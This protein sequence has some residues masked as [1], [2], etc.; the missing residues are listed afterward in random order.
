MADAAPE[1]DV[2]NE[3][4]RQ[5]DE[6]RFQH[7]NQ[8]L[9]NPDL[10]QN[11]VRGRV[12]VG[13]YEDEGRP[14]IR[15][16]LAHRDDDED[17]EDDA[18]DDL[19]F[20]EA[21]PSPMR[22]PRAPA[23]GGGGAGDDDDPFVSLYGSTPPWGNDDEEDKAKR[24]ELVRLGRSTDDCFLCNMRSTFQTDESGPM[25]LPEATLQE[26]ML[27]VIAMQNYRCTAKMMVDHVLLH[28]KN[29]TRPKILESRGLNERTRLLLSRPWFRQTVYDH[30]H[31]HNTSSSV[32][33]F[34][35]KRA[36]IE[37]GLSAT[38]VT[39]TIVRS[40]GGADARTALAA[41]NLRKRLADMSDKLPSVYKTELSAALERL[42]RARS[43]G[44]TQDDKIRKQYQERLT[45]RGGGGGE[46]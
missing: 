27:E 26:A 30:Y 18:E 37:G 42:K 45:H 29:D 17:D 2:A 4:N 13:G 35:A 21:P 9:A 38:A 28:F 15:R 3:I 1:R 33:F 43:D 25:C 31:D 19:G 6:L 10:P 12:A 20:G 23:G 11:R 24:A 46:R 8:H 14:A 41:V 5:L 34:A 39:N 44:S 32:S 16:R 36:H 40:K 7:Q 22:A